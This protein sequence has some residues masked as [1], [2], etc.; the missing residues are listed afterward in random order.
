MNRENE[1]S[2]KMFTGLLSLYQIWNI[3][4]QSGIQKPIF[5]VQSFGTVTKLGW[6]PTCRHEIAS[7]SNSNDR[8][9]HVWDVR[10]GYLPAATFYHHR[11]TVD[12]EFQP[13]SI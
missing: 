2:R 8:R 5:K 10:R 13:M 3:G 11:G 6:R 4:D 1:T 7:L 9:I 12:Q